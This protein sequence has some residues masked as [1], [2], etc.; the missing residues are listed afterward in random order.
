MK[1]KRVFYEL[2]QDEWLSTSKRI[3]ELNGNNE[4]IRSTDYSKNANN[5]WVE[6]GDYYLFE[7]SNGN[8]IKAENWDNYSS[9]SKSTL[10]I[11]EKG[12]FLLLYSAKQV[13]LKK[14]SIKSRNDEFNLFSTTTIEYDNN[15]NP[16]RYL[17]LGNL[18]AP[19]EFNSSKNNKVKKSYSDINNREVI[20]IYTYSYNDKDFPSQLNIEESKIYPNGTIIENFSETYSYN[21]K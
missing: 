10:K 13:Y 4:V 12:N 9:P 5:E 6:D 18:I 17:T 8:M 14:R 11:V 1:L 7:W 2:V 15:T 19:D 16:F 20:T 3:N 21:C